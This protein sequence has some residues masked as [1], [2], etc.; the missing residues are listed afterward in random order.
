MLSGNSRTSEAL[1][2][3]PWALPPSLWVWH[4]HGWLHRYTL[5]R[6]S[7]QETPN[8]LWSPIRTKTG[9]TQFAKKPSKVA[10]DVTL[11]F[12]QIKNSYNSWWFASGE[13]PWGYGLLSRHSG[14]LEG[15]GIPPLRAGAQGWWEGVKTT[16]DNQMWRGRM[17]MTRGQ[18][19]GEIK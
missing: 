3:R 8:P 1:G 18:R 5:T 16:P 11:T 2:V 14:H 13:H 7:S 19:R 17:K 10:S 15:D 6:P 12:F 4:P 9:T